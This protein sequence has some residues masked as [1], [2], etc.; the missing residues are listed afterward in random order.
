MK[1]YDGSG[2]EEMMDGN[3]Q[4]D[5]S[6]SL[7]WYHGNLLVTSE[8]VKLADTDNTRA[9]CQV[10]TRP[11]NELDRPPDRPIDRLTS[12]YNLIARYFVAG[13]MPGAGIM[14]SVDI[15]TMVRLA[16]RVCGVTR[17]M[18]KVGWCCLRSLCEQINDVS[19]SHRS[20]TTTTTSMTLPHRQHHHH[21]P[22]PPPPS[23]PQLGLAMSCQ[24]DLT[25]A[26]L[27][28]NVAVQVL[29]RLSAGAGANE[30]LWSFID[31]AQ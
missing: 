2:L 9:C 5:G 17:E 25:S 3:E 7:E 11:T 29:E 21:Q 6:P 16:Y 10:Y 15:P 23:S 31:H 12:L 1:L 13:G 28:S 20:L 19:T 14:E 30:N 26:D 18:D 24:D 22:P 27:T 8:S 4:S